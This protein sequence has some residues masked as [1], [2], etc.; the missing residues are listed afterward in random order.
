M[1]LVNT[2]LDFSLIEAGRIQAQYQPTDLATLTAELASVFRSAIKQAGL[3]L[4][5]DC[6]ALPEAVYVDRDLWEKIVF[7]L[8]SNAFKFTLSGS[9]TVTLFTVTLPLEPIANTTPFEAEPSDNMVWPGQLTGIR[10]LAIDDEVDSL[11][12]L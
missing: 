12:L 11:D 8:I 7:N 6:P 9:I 4:V 10:I 3:E 1:K 5:V 2:L